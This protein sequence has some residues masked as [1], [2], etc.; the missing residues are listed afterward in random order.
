MTFIGMMKI[1]TGTNENR[2]IWISKI[3]NIFDKVI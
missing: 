3:Y 1:I 2:G